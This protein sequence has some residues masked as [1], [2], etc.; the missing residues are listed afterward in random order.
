MKGRCRGCGQEIDW[1]KTKRGSSMP[2]DPPLVTVVTLE[3]EVVRG[4]RS[5]FA[6]CPKASKYRKK[7]RDQNGK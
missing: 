1:I 4:H 5:H 6:T 2:V 3:G 7:G